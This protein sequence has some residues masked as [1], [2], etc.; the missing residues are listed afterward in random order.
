MSALRLSFFAGCALASSFLVSPGRA[1]N[2]VAVLSTADPGYV[3][4]RMKDGKLTPQTYVVMKGHFIPGFTRDGSL[5]KM[6]FADIVRKLAPSLQQQE[7][8]PAKSIR[9]ADIMLVI[10]WGATSPRIHENQL[11][12]YSDMQRLSN[13]LSEAKAREAQGGGAI[14]GLDI[15]S[16]DNLLARP[17][18]SI[19]SDMD[20]AALE[21]A[22]DQMQ[23]D[24]DL[25]SAASILGVTAELKKE[26]S[27]MIDTP[28][29]VLIRTML[30]EDRYF[31]HVL[32]YDAKELFEHKTLK[33][34]WTARMSIRSPGINFAAASE[35]I[36]VV[37]GKFF[38][39]NQTELLA[40]PAKVREGH[41]EVGE[42]IV[43]R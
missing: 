30:E 9:D 33:R 14:V 26:Q 7:F 32:A 36:S 12:D 19:R 13:E 25:M 42:A 24:N 35:R 37:G 6:K 28:H 16:P 1:E 10:H 22:T 41:V 27:R 43:V 39:T 4:D 11:K 29:G 31:I 38:G 2:L 23:S 3:T 5:E 15:A 20:Y 21:T 17:S 34:L 40:A 18:Y 8:Y